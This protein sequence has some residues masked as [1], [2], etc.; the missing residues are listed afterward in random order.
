[1]SFFAGV[2]WG[3]APGR[4]VYENMRNSEFG[5][6]MIVESGKKGLVNGGFRPGRAL[7]INA[8]SAMVI[9]F[10]RLPLSAK[11][12]VFLERKRVHGAET[13]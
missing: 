5:P 4:Q 12:F 9:H 13:A 3:P 8:V 1:M 6:V 7:I 11:C 2:R 10:R